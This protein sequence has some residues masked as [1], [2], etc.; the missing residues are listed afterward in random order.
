M[1]AGRSSRWWHFRLD[2]SLLAGQSISRACL[3]PARVRDPAAPA[4]TAAPSGYWTIGALAFV[5]VNL[6]P[7][8]PPSPVAGG[9][10]DL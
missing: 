7:A 6:R 3:G 8:T 9:D 10:P 1:P 4:V 2:S 5:T